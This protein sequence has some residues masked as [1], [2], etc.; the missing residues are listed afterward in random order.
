MRSADGASSCLRQ[1]EMLNLTGG[2]QVL[3][4]A[5]YILD[6]YPGIDAVLIEQVD[7]VGPKP[8]QGRLD[9]L[10][11]MRGAAVESDDRTTRIELEPEL[12]GDDD[13]VPD[14][15]ERLTHEFLVGERS[16]ALGG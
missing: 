3:Y 8:L 6:R 2:D 5:G 12:G 7:P 13:V 11:D 16:I 1:S 10:A 4:R 9:D 15:F 14:G